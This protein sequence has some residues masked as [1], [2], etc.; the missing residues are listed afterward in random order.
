MDLR[1]EVDQEIIRGGQIQMGPVMMDI[2]LTGSMLEMI[3][4]VHHMAVEEGVE[5]AVVNL[6]G[7]G[8]VDNFQL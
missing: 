4:Q 3:A 1:L 7:R 5:E 6:N 2:H 8:E